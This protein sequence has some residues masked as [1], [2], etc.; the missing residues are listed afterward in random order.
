MDKEITRRTKR[1]LQSAYHSLS[2]V[3][4]TP[5]AVGLVWETSIPLTLT[6]GLFAVVGGL[7]PL[8]GLYINKLIIDAV[9]LAAKTPGSESILHILFLLGI[10][11]CIQVGSHALNGVETYIHFVLKNK[12][13][14]MLHRKVCERALAMDLQTFENPEFGDTLSRANREIGSRPMEV[15]GTLMLLLQGIIT[16]GSLS[17]MFALFQWYIVPLIFL[18]S[19]PNV[20]IQMRF[21]SK[22]YQIQYERTQDKRLADYFISLVLDKNIVQEV[23]LFNLGEYFL[24]KGLGLKERFNK[25]DQA[26]ENSKQRH[27]FGAGSGSVITVFLGVA[28]FTLEAANGRITL[29]DLALYTGALRR[30]LSTIA[31]LLRGIGSLYA[32]NIQLQNLFALFDVQPRI[33]VL[34]RPI[35]LP[36]DRIEQIEFRNV[37]YKYP[38]SDRWALK[39]IDLSIRAGTSVGLVGHNGAGKT[40]LIKLMTRLYDPTEGAIFVNGVDL[41]ALSLR[42]LHDR[43]GVIFQN[44]ARYAVPVGDNIGYGR[45]E[46][47]D[48]RRRTREAARQAEAETFIQGFPKGFEQRL[49]RVFDDSLDLSGGQWQLIAL[50]RA[51][52]RDAEVMVLDEPTAAVDVETEYK[53]FKKFQELMRNRTTLLVSHRLSA[54]RL[55]D[56]IVVLKNGEIRE[57]GDHAILMSH[58]GLYTDMFEKQAQ[59]Y[60]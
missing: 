40:T 38:D 21:S 34:E 18:V 33:K 32:L 35:A 51:F 20:L 45:I 50:A 15:F 27:V 41:R 2:V 44:F 55:V 4:K 12:L 17:I 16:L 37:S 57:T 42:D 19:V 54:I 46:A 3:G 25:E 14:L 39:N 9:V 7:V 53:L 49:G 36:G 59:A 1:V 43:M 6:V 11:I 13:S 22:S 58:N 48:H 29:G 60:R 47:L 24:G 23:K 30:C 56:Q 10:D 26:L 5:K 8:A 28:Y 52:M 31:S